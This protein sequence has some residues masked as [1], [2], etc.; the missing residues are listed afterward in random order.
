MFTQFYSPPRFNGE[1]RL[2]DERASLLRILLSDGHGLYFVFNVVQPANSQVAITSRL[3]TLSSD[4][5]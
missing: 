4:K 1:S 3:L 2:D 5:I